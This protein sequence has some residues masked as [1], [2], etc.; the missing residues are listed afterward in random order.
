[1][2]FCPCLLPNIENN[3]RVAVLARFNRCDVR[4]GIR[5]ARTIASQHRERKKSADDSH[6][7][8]GGDPRQIFVDEGLNRAS[9]F[10]EQKS[11]Q[12]EL[13]CPAQHA[14]P[15]EGEQVQF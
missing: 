7:K 12:H 15:D 6:Q 2:S 14:G 3:P 4:A 11:D 8:R 10:P 1:M 13:K 9:E 5:F